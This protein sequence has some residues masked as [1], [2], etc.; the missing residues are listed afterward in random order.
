LVHG[1]E[2]NLIAAENGFGNI[3]HPN[4]A[5]EELKKMARSWNAS[6]VPNQAARECIARLTVTV[7][8]PDPS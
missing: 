4:R 2:R 1:T 7:L 5:L 3:E 6:I 8:I